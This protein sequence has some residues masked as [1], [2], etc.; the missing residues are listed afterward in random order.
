MSDLSQTSRAGRHLAP[1]RRRLRAGR[2]G[3][4][5]VR[6][7]AGLG[8]PGVRSRG[9]KKCFGIPIRSDLS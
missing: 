2:A 8:A 4:A 5:A 1:G 3:V 7:A 9:R 6:G